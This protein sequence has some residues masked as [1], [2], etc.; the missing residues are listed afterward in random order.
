MLLLV[1]K[2]RCKGL[3]SRLSDR[4]RISLADA[5][6]RTTAR[7]PTVSESHLMILAEIKKA[8][9]RLD[10][11]SSTLKSVEQR[12]ESVENEYTR[13][14][15]PSSSADSSMERKKRTVPAIVRVSV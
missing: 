15:G 9:T 2:F 7:V 11:F 13:S 8:N 5:T 14:S 12:L 4:R 6:N 3:L 10:E 1:R